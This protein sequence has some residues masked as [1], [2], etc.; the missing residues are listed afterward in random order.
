MLERAIA[1]PSR[2]AVNILDLYA[3]AVSSNVSDAFAPQT[4]ADTYVMYV[5]GA[6]DT[7][8]RSMLDFFHRVIDIRKSRFMAIPFSV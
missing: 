6:G 8:K 3:N 2:L 5:N 7:F 1:A 4:D